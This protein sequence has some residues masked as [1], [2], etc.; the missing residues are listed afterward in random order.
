MKI[1][2]DAFGYYFGLGIQRTYAAVGKHY[3]VS[4]RA[5]TK[6][7]AKEKWQERITTIEAQ[8]RERSDATATH[9]LQVVNTRHLQMYRAT[10]VK[11]LQAMQS[12]SLTSGDAAA[13]AL[14]AAIRGERHVLGEPGDGDAISHKEVVA[15]FTRFL[16]IL[17]EMLPGEMV[18]AVV[19]RLDHEVMTGGP[20]S[21]RVGPVIDVEAGA[22]RS[23]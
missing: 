19:D 11:A 16:E 20:L 3:G 7:A 12:M 18:Q 13:R 1:P 14:D 4:A 23:A 17:R 6:R 5:V 22:I 10:Q 21:E 15:L 9:T 2:P 8:A